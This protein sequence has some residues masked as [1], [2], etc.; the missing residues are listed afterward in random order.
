MALPLLVLLILKGSFFLFASFIVLISFLGLL[1]YFAM[2]LPRRK[3]VGFAAALVGAVI[4]LVALVRVPFALL[5][6]LTLISLLFACIYLFKPQ[7][8]STAGAEFGL[9]IAG[10]LYV[11]LLLAHLLLLRGFLHGVGWVFL[12]LFIVMSSDSLAYYVGTSFGRHKLYPAV[13]PNKSV[14]GAIGGLV[15][16]LIGAFLAR[17]TVFSDLGIIDCIITALSAGILAQLGDLFES[18]LK[19]SFG[20]KDSGVMIPGHGGILDRL[21]S[22]LFAAPP[23]FYYAYFVFYPRMVG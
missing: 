12:L 15:G 23:L 16:A 3:L 2:A 22:I 13:S 8:I 9:T 6:I 18:L 19:R 4:P 11:P 14:E 10:F 5:L 20:V 1:E 17:A 21:D 7:D